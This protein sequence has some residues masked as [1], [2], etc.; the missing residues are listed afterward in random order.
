MDYNP[1]IY[2]ETALVCLTH[3]KNP[4]SSTAHP[5][6]PPLLNPPLPFRGN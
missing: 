5:K 2:D 1:S 3:N 4:D 6:P